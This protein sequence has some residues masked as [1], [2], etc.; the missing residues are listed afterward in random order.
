MIEIKEDLFVGDESDCFYNEKEGW[1]VIHTCKHPCHQKAVGYKGSLKKNHPYYLILERGNH[2]FLNM[3]DM[4]VPLSHEF[5][6]PIVTTAL[7]FIDRNIATKKILIHCNLAQSRSPALAL[8]F[9]AKR[10]GIINNESYQRAKEDF[11]KLYLN[12]NPGKGVESY[13]IKHWGDLE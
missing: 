6:E 10:K 5:T 3:V 11:I 13:L 7:D 4:D 12:Y 2:L 9:L 1:A 8:L